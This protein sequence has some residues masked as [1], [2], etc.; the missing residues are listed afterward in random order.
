MEGE[1]SGMNRRF[2]IYKYDQGNVYRP[3]IDGAW[4]GSGVID[5]AY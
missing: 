1:L 5:D 4:P 3:H 2:R